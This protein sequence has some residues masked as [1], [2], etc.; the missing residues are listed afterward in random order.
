M[1]KLPIDTGMHWAGL[2]IYKMIKRVREKKLN[3]EM[4][5][6]KKQGLP[7]VVGN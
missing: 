3:K 6:R 1:V 2:F 7:I 5:K 4:M